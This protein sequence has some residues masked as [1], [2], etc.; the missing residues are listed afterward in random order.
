VHISLLAVQKCNNVTDLYELP[1][2]C[3]LNSIDL[4][5]FIS[6]Y[7]PASPT[8]KTAGYGCYEADSA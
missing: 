6:R 3:P 4:N 8:E 5:A 2:L 1:D 7:G